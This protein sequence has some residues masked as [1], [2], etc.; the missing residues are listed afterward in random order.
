MEAIKHVWGRPLLSPPIGKWGLTAF[1]APAY[2]AH[3]MGQRQRLRD[4]LRVAA[5]IREGGVSTDDPFSV[6]TPALRRMPI[7]TTSVPDMVE[8][9]MTRSDMSW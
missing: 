1:P 8:V 2:A 7:E 5:P 3:E 6:C 9:G 4:V